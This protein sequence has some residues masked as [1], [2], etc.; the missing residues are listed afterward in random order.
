MLIEVRW[1][2][3]ERRVEGSVGGE[4]GREHSRV[5][6]VLLF[7]ANGAEGEAVSENRCLN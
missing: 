1:L 5:G 2:G 3:R 4:D 6:R 7:I